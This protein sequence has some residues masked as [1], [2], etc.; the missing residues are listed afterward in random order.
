MCDFICFLGNIFPLLTPY[1]QFTIES[2]RGKYLVPLST[3]NSA[4]P[5]ATFPEA[6]TIG[7]CIFYTQTIGTMFSSFLPAGFG[8]QIL[9]QVFPKA[10]GKALFPEAGRW[11]AGVL[12]QRLLLRRRRSNCGRL[13]CASSFPA[14][15]KLLPCSLLPSN[16]TV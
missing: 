16:Y 8:V 10:R 2:E 13:A 12:P 15:Q 4:S 11:R 7:I 14:S 6:G 1:I 9:G 3:V 5:A